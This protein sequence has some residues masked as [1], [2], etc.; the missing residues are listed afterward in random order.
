MGIRWL[1][2]RSLSRAT[3]DIK[4]HYVTKEDEKKLFDS[5]GEIETICERCK[6]PL[7][8]IETGENTYT[9]DEIIYAD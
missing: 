2:S 9:I 5:E 6:T 4:G 8:L 7:R 1:F 3:C